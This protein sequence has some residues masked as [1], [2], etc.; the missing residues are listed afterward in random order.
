MIQGMSSSTVAL[1][2]EGGCEELNSIVAALAILSARYAAELQA[3]AQEHELSPQMAVALLRL[4]SVGSM[5]MSEFARIISCDAGNLSGTIDR[6]E[7]AGLAV[8]AA[9]VSDKRVRIVRVTSEGRRVATKLGRKLDSTRV[10]A[11]LRHL[12]ED[13][14]RTLRGMLE[15]LRAASD[16]QR[17]EA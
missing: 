12:G 16:P 14:R 13:E 11:A 9:C 4:G 8:R 1:P 10:I 5:R 7:E 17:T 6:L 15:Q 2:V 3:A